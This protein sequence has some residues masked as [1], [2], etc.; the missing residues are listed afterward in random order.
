MCEGTC[1]GVVP[2]DMCVC[3]SQ[4]WRQSLSLESWACH[5]SSC[6]RARTLAAAVLCS[7]PVL[8]L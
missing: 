4:L 3:L 5:L 8:G 1:G 6:A 2:K 7:T